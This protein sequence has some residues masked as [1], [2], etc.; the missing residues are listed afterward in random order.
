MQELIFELH[1]LGSTEYS[2]G[3]NF[4]RPA[5]PVLAQAFR[6][7][8]LGFNGYKEVMTQDLKNARLLSR[9][10][11]L[12]G[13]FEVLSDIHKPVN[14]AVGAA[15]KVGALDEEDAEYYEPGL[16]VVAFKFSDEWSKEHPNVQQSWVQTL[17]RVKG[18]IV[19]NYNLSPEVDDIQVLRVVVRETLEESLLESL[20][21][22]IFSIAED[23]EN[24][25]SP[26]GAL[27]A[28][29]H[30]AAS[31]G[32]GGSGK[33]QHHK[34][35]NKHGRHGLHRPDA[36]TGVKATGYAKQC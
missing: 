27:A 13:K 33:G 20:V 31:G 24:K 28:L 2:F 14:A 15:A 29:G 34:G 22:D 18:W 19:P 9:A 21:Q 26:T 12:S 30:Q 1:Y 8:S 32:V 7:L 36:G 16:P 10:L 11:E 35:N 3:L 5:A 6:F 25:D 23:L 4:S 17:L